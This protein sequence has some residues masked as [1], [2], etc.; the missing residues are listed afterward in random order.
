M[1]RLQT[2]RISMFVLGGWAVSNIAVGSVGFSSLDT[3]LPV[4]YMQQW[5]LNLQRELKSNLALEIG[6]LGSK[7]TKLDWRNNANQATLDADPS[8]AG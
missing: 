3:T 2:D 6:Y 5:S 8:R 1:R 7:G 4:G